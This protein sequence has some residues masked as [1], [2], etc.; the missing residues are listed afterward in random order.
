MRRGR[1]RER[2]RDRERERQTVEMREKG[3]QA[4]QERKRE[5]ET[6]RMLRISYTVK[7]I[8]NKTVSLKTGSKQRDH[9]YIGNENASPPPL[10]FMIQKRKL[11]HLLTTRVIN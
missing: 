11:D 8:Y 3:G 9:S 10:T 7:K 6:R 4:Y 5:A 1:N 2:E